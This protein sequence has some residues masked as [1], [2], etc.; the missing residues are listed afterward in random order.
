VNPK[1]PNGD[2]LAGRHKL[3]N[4]TTGLDFSHLDSTQ[5]EAFCFDLLHC[6]DF[7][8]IDWRKGTGTHASPA[9][10]GRDIQCE[11]HHAAPD[12]TL[13]RETW[14]IEC[15]H[16]ARSVPP[17]TIESL[18]SW[19]TAERPAKALIITS[20]YLSNPCKEY[21]QKYVA[22][23][24]PPFKIHWWENAKLK[25]LTTGFTQ[26]LN[27]YGLIEREA[28]LDLLH[29]AHVRFLKMTVPN[30]LSYLFSLLDE[31]EPKQRDDTLGLTFHNVVKPRYKEAPPGYKGTIGEL[32]LDPS[33]LSHI[34]RE[35]PRTDFGDC[36]ALLGLL[37]R[38]RRA[39][40]P[41]SQ[42]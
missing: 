18:L 25:M 34:Q 27:R 7:K 3:K 37:H 32:M 4:E 35:M 30:T 24:K 9:D 5:F 14:F 6:L 36:G 31:L 12:G 22:N 41:L 29:P 17:T 23:N 15:K 20:S 28:C 33:A 38:Q 8:H 21:I 10:Q 19:A 40:V 2:P 39:E 42:R 16:L 26:L 13:D 1:R 11:T